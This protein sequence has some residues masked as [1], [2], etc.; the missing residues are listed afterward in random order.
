MCQMLLSHLFTPSLSALLQLI[1]VCNTD[2]TGLTDRQ[3]MEQPCSCV[4][5]TFSPYYILFSL[6]SKYF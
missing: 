3:P 4:S 1:T 5:M 6:L 2:D